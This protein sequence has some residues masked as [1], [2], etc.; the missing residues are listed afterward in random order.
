MPTQKIY[1]KKVSLDERGRITLPKE[2]RTKSKI[3]LLESAGPDS[4]K[5]IPQVSVPLKDAE[6]VES[7]KKSLSQ[8][9]KGRTK[10][11]PKKWID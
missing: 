11:I 2:L 4:I 1:K 10:K 3:Y 8:F 6:I 9:K 7:L 5:L